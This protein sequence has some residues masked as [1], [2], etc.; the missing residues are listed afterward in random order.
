M[1]L[2]WLGDGGHRSGDG[3]HRSCGKNGKK[4]GERRCFYVPARGFVGTRRLAGRRFLIRS[5]AGTMNSTLPCRTQPGRPGMHS[6]PSLVQRS[7]LASKWG[8]KKLMRQVHAHLWLDPIQPY[9]IRHPL[10]RR[11]KHHVPRAS[12]G[13]VRPMEPNPASTIWSN[14]FDACLPGRTSGSHHVWPAF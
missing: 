5:S 4:E 12:F 14:M 9:F 7:V 8:Q 6:A 1:S 13:K 11:R 2:L 3:G 10:A